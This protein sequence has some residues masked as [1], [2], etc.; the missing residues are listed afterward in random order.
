MS[1]SSFSGWDILAFSASTTHH[2]WIRFKI[3]NRSEAPGTRV[4][5]ITKILKPQASAGAIFPSGE[6]A[7]QGLADYPGWAVS[8]QTCFCLEWEL[9]KDREQSSL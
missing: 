1:F 7:P 8:P 6:D 2:F 9:S 4:F 5:G 3:I